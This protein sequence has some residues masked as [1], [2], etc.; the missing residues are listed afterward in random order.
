MNSE[1]LIF[2]QVPR[3]VYLYYVLNACHRGGPVSLA[4]HVYIKNLSI[5]ISTMSL[6]NLL[7][8]FVKNV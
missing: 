3:A 4:I 7:F 2:F 5:C 6:W 1:P 8:S